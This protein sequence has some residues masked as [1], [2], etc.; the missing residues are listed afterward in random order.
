MENRR[1]G[2]GVSAVTNATGTHPPVAMSFALL[3]PICTPIIPSSPLFSRFSS[4]GNQHPWNHGGSIYRV[5]MAFKADLQAAH[6]G[7][8]SQSANSRLSI[9]AILPLR[10]EADPA[11]DS[12]G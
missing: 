2:R 4:V 6:W 3:T 8:F 12:E 10:T 1:S 11:Q 7:G 5:A 9:L